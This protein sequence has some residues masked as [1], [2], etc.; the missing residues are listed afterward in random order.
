MLT[1]IKDPHH[2]VAVMM[3]FCRPIG[4]FNPRKRMI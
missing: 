4:K 3:Y 1:L 2:T